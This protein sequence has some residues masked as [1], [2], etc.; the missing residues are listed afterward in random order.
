MP[1]ATI[2]NHQMYYEIHGQG[3]PAVYIGGWD[4]FCHGRHHYLARGI[5]DE[6]QVLIIDYRGI[7]E[8]DDDPSVPA[9]TELQ[10]DDIIELLDQLGWKET[11]F[12]GLVGIGA[13]IGHWVALKR[14]DLVRCMVNMGCWVHSDKTLTDIL[15]GFGAIHEHAGFAA[16]QEM[17]AAMSFRPD[18][19]EEKRDV[20][21]GPDGVW[22][23]LNG[24]LEAH[25]RFIEACIAH[26]I[27]DR[28][29]DIPHPTLVIHAGR[30]TITGPWSTLPLEHGLPNAEGVTMPDVAHVVAGKAEK[31]AFNEILFPFLAKH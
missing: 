10:A 12:I 9:T 22:G 7:G 4:T 17:V 21:L 14:P 13:C 5:T 19:Y 3:K 26:D 2:N 18:Y 24:R 8:S 28:L 23:A 20:L 30:D 25:Q 29:G 1:I 27:R 15:N 11:Y 31:I 16:F 6:H